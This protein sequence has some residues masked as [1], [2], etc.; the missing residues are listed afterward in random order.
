MLPSANF[1]EYSSKVRQVRGDFENAVLNFLVKYLEMK[2]NAP[3][4]LNGLYKESDYPSVDELRRK[5]SFDVDIS[6]IMNAD[7]FRVKIGEE[8]V[9]DIKASIEERLGKATEYAMRSLWERLSEAVGRMAETLGEQKAVF[10][11]S[12]VENIEDLIVLLPRLNLTNDTSLN[13]MLASMKS[14]TV[15]SPESLRKSGVL[16]KQQAEKARVFLKQIES[17]LK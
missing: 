17:H 2:K 1:I 16:R 5:F 4:L 8:E 7:D 14:L 6:P 13:A 3:K 12:L 10:R 11:D 15:V 9:A